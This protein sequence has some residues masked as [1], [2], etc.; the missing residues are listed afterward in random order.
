M[1]L[2]RR[3]LFERVVLNQRVNTGVPRQYLSSKVEQPWVVLV[4]LEG[5]KPHEPVKTVVVR[6]DDTGAP[7]NATGLTFELKLLPVGVV[8][9]C[10]V[11]CTLEDHFCTFLCNTV[12]VCVCVCVFQKC[13]CLATTYTSQRL[14][15]C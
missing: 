5:G 8:I 2:R 13:E 7:I 6:G 10:T 3:S 1:N 14:H 9:Q 12:C 4:V 15:R 11:P